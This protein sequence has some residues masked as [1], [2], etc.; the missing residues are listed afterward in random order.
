MLEEEENK[1]KEE[2]EEVKEEAEEEQQQTKH[3]LSLIFRWIARH[4]YSRR[5]LNICAV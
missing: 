3:K 5:Y 2:A 1:E 4:I